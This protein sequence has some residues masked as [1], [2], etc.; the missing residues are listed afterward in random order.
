MK[1]SRWKNTLGPLTPTLTLPVPYLKS[2]GASLPRVVQVVVSAVILIGTRQPVE[3]CQ[4]SPVAGGR[5]AWC[6]VNLLPSFQASTATNRRSGH[7]PPSPALL[8]SSSTPHRTPPGRRRPQQHQEQKRE[9]TPQPHYHEREL[10][11]PGLLPLHRL[12][13]KM[14]AA[15][16]MAARSRALVA[17]RR[18]MGGPP[19]LLVVSCDARTADAYCSLV[20]MHGFCS[21]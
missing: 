18:R 11:G 12:T 6:P 8:S 17:S 3:T 16:S 2:S 1:N 21:D 4:L 10:G 13:L 7:V 20:G 19:R 14:A 15:A 9:E 5:A